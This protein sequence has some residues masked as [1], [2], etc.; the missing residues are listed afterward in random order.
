[1]SAPACQAGCGR[2]PDPGMFMCNF[3]WG[4]LTPQQRRRVWEAWTQ[5]RDELA[6]AQ[7]H[8]EKI[9]AEAIQIV[10]AELG[11]SST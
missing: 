5:V 6:G 2:V 4:L 9:K 11:A 1:M 8:F 10:K 7:G 3:C